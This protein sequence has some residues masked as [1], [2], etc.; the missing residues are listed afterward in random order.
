MSDID[1]ADRD[2][3]ERAIYLL[4]LLLLSQLADSNAE[5]AFDVRKHLSSVT[6]SRPLS[7]PPLVHMLIAAK[8]YYT[9]INLCVFRFLDFFSFLV[10]SAL[11]CAYTT[12][13]VFI[14]SGA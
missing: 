3:M 9:L 6:R 14:R 4:L 2:R 7:S 1:I 5:E 12:L 10:E 11:L 8:R 13:S